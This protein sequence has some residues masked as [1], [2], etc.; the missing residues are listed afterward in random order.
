MNLHEAIREKNTEEAINLIKSGADIES[1]DKVGL[2]PLFLAAY[3][4][5]T[6]VADILLE[7]GA[8]VDFINYIDSTTPLHVAVRGGNTDIVNLLVARKANVNSVTNFGESPLHMAASL[9]DTD[10]VKLLLDSGAYIHAREKIFGDTPLHS[11]AYRGQTDVAD[12]LLEKG[13]NIHA[14]NEKGETALHK[15]AY[16]NSRTNSVSIELLLDK[17]ANIH[18]VNEKGETALHIAAYHGENLFHAEYGRNTDVVNLLLDRGAKINAVDQDIETALHKAAFKGNT[19]VVNLL[20]NRGADI[21]A[22]QIYGETPLHSA[23]HH[24]HVET[25]SF[26][27]RRAADIEARDATARAPLQVAINYNKFQ[28]T[29][30][31]IKGTEKIFDKLTIPN[32]SLGAYL[33]EQHLIATSETNEKSESLEND[34]NSL[35]RVS[36]INCAKAI[37]GMETTLKA[38]ALLKIKMGALRSGVKDAYVMTLNFL[39]VFTKF[40]LLAENINHIIGF[41]GLYDAPVDLNDILSDLDPKSSRSILGECRTPLAL[42]QCSTDI[43]YTDTIGCCT[44]S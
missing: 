8:N 22:V 15:A 25:V 16:N 35:I 43:K 21:E 18:A 44:I 5:Q 34:E 2:S 17:G 26:L 29:F 12:I 31:L 38:K 37:F 30:C 14:V 23:I 41:V 10:L 7:K 39:H 27:V 20:V 13:A 4:G 6:D 36:M 24:D 9:G 11:A 1:Y 32:N 33:K 42:N 28:C 40:N 3:F 19:D